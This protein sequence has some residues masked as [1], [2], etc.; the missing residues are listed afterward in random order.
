MGSA[1]RREIRVVP[2]HRKTPDVDQLVLAVLDIAQ[3][4]TA[5]IGAAGRES[6]RDERGSA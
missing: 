1:R 5:T 3:A 6:I 4:R 2:K